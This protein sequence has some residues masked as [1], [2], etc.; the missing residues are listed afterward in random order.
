M[1]QGTD[2]H[3]AQHI[4]FLDGFQKKLTVFWTRNG[5]TIHNIESTLHKVSFAFQ[6]SPANQK[7]MYLCLVSYMSRCRASWV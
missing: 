6:Y 7:P 5:S 4:T 2:E 1:I 3:F